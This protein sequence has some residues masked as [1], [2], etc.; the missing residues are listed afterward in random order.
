MSPNKRKTG[1]NY[2]LSIPDQQNC[3]VYTY[4]RGDRVNFPDR[5]PRKRQAEDVVLSPVTFARRYSASEG[6]MPAASGSLP[7]KAPSLTD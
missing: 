6:C 3:D 7:D 5:V 4:Y 2:M 1:E